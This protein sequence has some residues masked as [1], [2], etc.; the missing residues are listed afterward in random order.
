[1][2]ELQPPAPRSIPDFIAHVVA[3]PVLVARLLSSDDRRRFLDEVLNLAH[4][5]GYLFTAEELEVTMTAN[6][7]RWIERSL[8]W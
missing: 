1:M 7:R 3:D 8:P 2:S 6:R 4:A 5:A